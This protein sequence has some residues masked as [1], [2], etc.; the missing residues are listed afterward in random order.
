MMQYIETFPTGKR[1]WAFGTSDLSNRRM[2][3]MSKLKDPVSIQKIFIQGSDQI[4]QV[5][6]YEVLS[7][8]GKCLILRLQ[9]TRQGQNERHTKRQTKALT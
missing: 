3:G 7:R 5:S 4:T 9:H 1:Q 6:E 8:L 2:C